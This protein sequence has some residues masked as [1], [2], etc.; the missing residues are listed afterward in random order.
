MEK[1]G[2]NGGGGF[3]ELKT[4]GEGEKGK[5]IPMDLRKR[6]MRTD[7]KRAIKSSNLT[8]S[9]DVAMRRLVWQCS[10]QVIVPFRD[11]GYRQAHHTIESQSWHSVSSNHMTQFN[12]CK[13]TFFCLVDV[14][15]RHVW[16][17]EFQKVEVEQFDVDM[18]YH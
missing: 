7:M 4:I 5:T 9:I 15:A 11:G 14:T 10:R 12:I 8:S 6:Q 18:N 1:V 16:H 17:E 2:E 3:K 13:R